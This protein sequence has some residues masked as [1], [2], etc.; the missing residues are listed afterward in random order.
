MGL[1]SQ[2][3]P[4]ISILLP[5]Y[6][7]ADVLPFAIRSVL[8]QTVQDF[9]LLIVG[10]GCT[11]NT[12]DVVKSFSDS[13][14]QW[15]DLPKAPN[16]GYANRN[17]ALKSARGSYIAFM[18]HDD[19]WLSDHLEILLNAFEDETVDIAYSRPLWVIPRG[20]IVPGT[21]NLNFYPMLE[22]FLNKERNEIPA[23]CFVHRRECFLKY[24]YWDESLPIAGD[25]DFWVRIIKGG[26]KNNFA[27]IETPTC[28]HFK[29]NWHK[30]WYEISFGFRFWKDLFSKEKFLSSQLTVLIPDQL[31]EQE[32]I[33]NEMSFD[34]VTWNKKIRSAI[35]QAL[36]LL[37]N[38]ITMSESNL[39][40]S[41]MAWLTP[42]RITNI[43]LFQYW[44]KKIKKRLS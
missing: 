24:G 25:L 5:T 42:K 40:R 12:A 2:E 3:N 36:D 44:F 27:Y 32:A 7:R 18:A 33:W 19:L 1:S 8:A 11:D 26:G 23:T 31:T 41:V 9:E 6:N 22:K 37:V 34:S 17:L 15:F 13:R 43:A 30:K 28:L 39:I 14:I 4:Q 16:F 35:Q 38:N 10:D 20:M 29:A 21:F